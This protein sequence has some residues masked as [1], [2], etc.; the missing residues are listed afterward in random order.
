[1]TK[2]ELFFFLPLP[3]PASNERVVQLTFVPLDPGL[4]L[5]K[6]GCAPPVHNAPC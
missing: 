4:P 5:R 2:D 1:M 3:V 6:C